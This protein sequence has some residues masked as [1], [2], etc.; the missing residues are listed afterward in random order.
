MRLRPNGQS[1][2][3]QKQAYFR[4]HDY[5]SMIPAH[6]VHVL[7][8]IRSPAE[9]QRRRDQRREAKGAA[10]RSKILPPPR[11][12]GTLTIPPLILGFLCA[13]LCAS[14]SL[15]GVHISDWYRLRRIRDRSPP[16]LTGRPHSSS[17][18]IAPHGAAVQ[19]APRRSE[20][21][22]VG[23]ECRSRWSPYH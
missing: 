16:T 11:L 5:Y 22:R 7:S 8:S 15:R 10:G 3:S 21:R 20:E 23:K 4:N 13:Y 19:P 9:T 2:A 12:A 14:A 1:R 17:S 18:G 6:R